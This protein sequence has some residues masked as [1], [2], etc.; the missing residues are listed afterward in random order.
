MDAMQDA[1]NIQVLCH[2]HSDVCGQLHSNRA[3]NDQL[4]LLQTVFE[5]RPAFVRGCLRCLAEIVCTRGNV[6]ILDW[7]SQFGIE[8][9]ST[10]PIR[11][12][13]GRG[14]VELL[15]CFYRNGLEATDPD[16]LE[17][18]IQ[19]DQLEAVRWLSE[20]GHPVN[21]LGLVKTAGE[22]GSAPL[23]RWLVE[24]GPPL[25]LATARAL[26]IEYRH[27]DSWMGVRERS[28]RARARGSP[29]R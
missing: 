21:S 3:T 20:H 19:K 18:A 27:R 2:F 28:E 1:H 14:D 11:D 10:A 23:L 6:A 22:C 13:I 8:L 9:R 5:Q 25:D 17:L 26:V 7:V 15:R 4:K 16:L 12:A 29:Q 24:H